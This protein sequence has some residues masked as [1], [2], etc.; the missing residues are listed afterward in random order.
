VASAAATTVIA[1]AAAF[2]AI[3]VAAP[4][5]GPG[6]L[7]VARLLIA[8]A[9]LACFI[10]VLG[11]VRLPEPRDLPRIV[12]CGLTGMAGYQYLLNSGER[13]VSAGAA[14]L[15]V[16]TSPLFAAILARLALGEKI[17]ARGRTGLAVGFLGAIV[18]TIGQ[19]NGIH[20]SGH[21]V[22][23]LVAAVLFALFF[24]VQRPLLARY[25]SFE[26]TCYATWSGS[27]LTIPFLPSLVSQARNAQPHPIEA[28][29]FLAVVSSTLGFVSWAY[30]QQ[31][32]PVA[33]AVNILYLVPFTAIGIGWIALGEST[34]ALAIAGGVIAL[35][36]VGLSRSRSSDRR[37]RCV[38]FPTSGS[39]PTS[40]SGSSRPAT[41]SP[42]QTPS[43]CD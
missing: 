35:I 43:R 3:R 24:V 30:V 38:H 34:H 41:T 7:T 23:V 40:R 5:F 10:P 36:G 28:V 33:T 20:L 26:L 32:L 1:W 31:H 27:I 8:S 16:N 29:I 42:P 17:T 18:M 19:G 11:K 21:A 6:E 9:V 37:K 12:A 22:L 15:L 13:S 39:K 25:S 4:A 2:V 14:S